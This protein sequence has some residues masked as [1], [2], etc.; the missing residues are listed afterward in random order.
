MYF[1]F[2]KENWILEYT[3]RI[4]LKLQMFIYFEYARI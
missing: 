2:V 1:L 3:I 4:I